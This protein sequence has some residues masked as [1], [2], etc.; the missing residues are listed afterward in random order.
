[1]NGFQ[2]GGAILGERGYPVVGVWTGIF[3]SNWN[4]CGY[5]S[6]AIVVEALTTH[7][8]DQEQ[9]EWKDWAGEGHSWRVCS[10]PLLLIASRAGSRI[11]GLPAYC[12]T[13]RRLTRISGAE[14]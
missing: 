1:M 14:R 9:V 6:P 7:T 5:R 13:E 8:C 4:T 2:H 12:A 11:E 3:M 10:G